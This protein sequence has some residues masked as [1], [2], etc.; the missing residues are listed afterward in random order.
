MCRKEKAINSLT[1]LIEPTANECFW[2][3]VI[4]PNFIPKT[5]GH[6]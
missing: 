2:R 1:R 3:T 6:I 4:L 5:T